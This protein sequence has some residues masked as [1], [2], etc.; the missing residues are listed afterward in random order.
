MLQGT[1]RAEG[2]LWQD[3]PFGKPCGTV[4]L[5]QVLRGQKPHFPPTPKT[6]SGSEGLRHAKPSL[7]L[8]ALIAGAAAY[9]IHA[10][11]SGAETHGASLVLVNLFWLGLNTLALARVVLAALWRP[12]LPCGTLITLPA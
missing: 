3:H 1:G 2:N 9:G 7:A 5:V 11:L 6:L 4:A 10:W 12:R 8:L